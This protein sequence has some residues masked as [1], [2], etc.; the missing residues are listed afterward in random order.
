MLEAPTLALV[1]ATFLLGGFV[2]GAIGLGLPVVVLATLA[3]VMPLQSV[4][5][6]LLAPSIV[7]NLWQMVDGPH[8]RALVQRLR[9]FLAMAVLGVLIGVRVLAST[10][11][12]VLL[13]ALGVLLFLYASYALAAPRVPP[14]G[15]RERWMS[16]AAGGLG[17]VLF[18]ATGIFIMPGLIYLEALRMPRDQF[19]QAM[20][21]TFTVISGTLSFGM[22]GAALISADLA[23]LSAIALIPTLAGQA[24][25][26]RLRRRISEAFF[27]RLFF[28]A[29]LASGAY[30][31]LRSGALA[32]LNG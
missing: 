4:L 18:G 27:R 6:I 2:K 1:V 14:P 28:V 13:G 15:A 11:S 21:L 20:G 32:L 26:A 3:L 10:P 24:L 5:A 9:L 7:S 8:L 25:G 31:M 12:E 29:L 30:M 22:A 17:G 16:P 23:I 19:V